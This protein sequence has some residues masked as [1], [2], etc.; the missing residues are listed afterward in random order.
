MIVSATRRPVAHRRAAFT[1]LEVLVVVAILVILAAVAGVYV[2]GYLEDAKIDTARSQCALFETQCKAYMAKNGGNPPQSL[3]ELV[4]PSDGRQPLIEG[5]PAALNDPWQ[6]GG[7]YQL[8]LRQDNY[9][10]PDPVVYV[11]SPRTGQPIYSSK[12]SVMGS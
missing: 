4:A 12:R 11:T 8:E 5:G 6:Q 7:Q 1:L 10:N 2:F 3:M 9:G